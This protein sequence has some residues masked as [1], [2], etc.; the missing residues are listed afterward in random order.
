M[1]VSTLYL[2]WP[3]ASSMSVVR[4]DEFFVNWSVQP[5]ILI[6]A[7]GGGGRPKIG[8]WLYLYATSAGRRLDL[9]WPRYRLAP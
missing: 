7:T 9:G 3:V 5:L 4:V 2:T 8:R 1:G 6:M